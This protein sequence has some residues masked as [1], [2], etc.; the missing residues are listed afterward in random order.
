LVENSEEVKNI[1][2]EIQPHVPMTL[3]LWPVVVCLQV[4]G[5]VGSAKR[6]AQVVAEAL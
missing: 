2:E 4:K 3:Q 6:P 1:L 5:A